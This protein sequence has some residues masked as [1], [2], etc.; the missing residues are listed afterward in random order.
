MDVPV[1]LYV[2]FLD[3]GKTTAIQTGFESDSVTSADRVLLLRCE[4]GETDYAP[5]RFH[6]DVQIADIEGPDDL[7]PE[8]LQRLHDKYQPDIVLVEYNGMWT[9]DKLIAALPEEWYIYEQAE[10]ENAVTFAAYNANMRNLTYEHL[11]MSDYVEFNRVPEGFDI[12]PLH[13]IVRGANRRCGIG[14][15][16]DDGHV[17]NDEIE[18][19]LPFDINA[20]VIEIADDD[21]GLWYT[22]IT[23]DCEKYNGKTVKFK[24]IIVKQP[25]MTKTMF[26]FGRKVMYCCAADIN[27]GA[28]ICEYPAAPAWDTYTWAVITAKIKVERHRGYKGKGPVL[29]VNSIARTSPPENEVATLW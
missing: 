4:D 8:N 23:E 12:M 18:D 22:D 3:G 17:E 24:G 25:D 16:Y 13:K 21:Y 6:A 19:P 26:F 28:L 9:T 29:Y 5:E 27:Y 1:L 15:R 7:T 11:S 20:P 2:G 14:Y 10:V